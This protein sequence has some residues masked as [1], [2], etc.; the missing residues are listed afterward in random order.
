MSLHVPLPRLHLPWATRAAGRRRAT[1]TSTAS[2]AC[3]TPADSPPVWTVP[4]PA[5]DLPVVGHERVRWA[6]GDQGQRRVVAIDQ[7]AGRHA[8]PLWDGP[9]L[10]TAE[11]LARAYLDQAQYEHEF[12]P[13]HPSAESPGAPRPDF[14]AMLTQLRGL[15]VHTGAVEIVELA[16]AGGAPLR[17]VTDLLGYAVAGGLAAGERG[18]AT[19]LAL[20]RRVTAESD[21][22]TRAVHA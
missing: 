22:L 14:E 9:V 7:P 21:R 16:L 10:A 11:D 6:I 13:L 8:P 3:A 20:V 15:P 19:T 1:V 18:A 12:G 4:D 2:T 5:R 17:A